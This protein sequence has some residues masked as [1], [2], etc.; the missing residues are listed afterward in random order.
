MP[1]ISNIKYFCP[2]PISIVGCP[3]HESG[4]PQE[5][6]GSNP[7]LSMS[8]H[9]THIDVSHSRRLKWCTTE[10]IA[11]YTT[12]LVTPDS[13]YPSS[14]GTK[15]LPNVRPTC[16]RHRAG[17]CPFEHHTGP[18]FSEAMLI[19]AAGDGPRCSCFG[20]ISC[21]VGG[22]NRGRPAR[23]FHLPGAAR[24]STW[25]VCPSPRREQSGVLPSNRHG[26]N[27]HR[28]MLSDSMAESHN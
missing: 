17:V 7:L 27:H 25:G 19:A 1:K 12:L 3:R 20:T 10:L 13:H 26:I 8:S 24:V 11:G 4:L 16:G 9:R 28:V 18:G 21:T 14:N 6:N 2:S 23:G 15:R 5:W 22:L